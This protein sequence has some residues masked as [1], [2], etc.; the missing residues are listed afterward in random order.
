MNLAPWEYLYI[1]F[2]PFNFHDLFWPLVWAS[3]VFLAGQVVLY[4]VRTRQLRRFE[5]LVTMQEWL[6]WTGII[7][8]GLVIVE[9][10]FRWYFLFVFATL[11]VGLGT[12]VWV[13]F[14]YWPPQIAGY[15]QQLRRA[16]FFTQARY[17][18]PEA[19][20]RSRRRRRR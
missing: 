2:T 8:F 20:I 15:N 14:I 17:K 13:R 3:V 19:T 18:H 1:A 11:V 6:L 16:R 7:T 4:N 12:Y 5:P 9:A 10:I